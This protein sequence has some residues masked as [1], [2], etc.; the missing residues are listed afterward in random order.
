[1][2]NRMIV[3][4]TVAVAAV[5]IV[6][7]HDLAAV[8][9]LE[10]PEAATSESP[11]GGGTFAYTVSAVPSSSVITVGAC[12]YFTVTVTQNGV[13]VNGATVSVDDPVREVCANA[14]RTNSQGKVTYYVESMCPATK[15]CKVGKY[16]FR[17]YAGGSSGTGLVTVNT[18][19]PSGLDKLR[20]VNSSGNTYKVNVVV[21]GVNRGTTTIS[22]HSTVSLL[23]QSGFNNSTVV[24]T[25][26]NS[27]GTTLWRA[28]QTD[29]GTSNPRSNTF[30]NP[31]Y[32]NYWAN[33]G[34][35]LNGTTV[36]RALH[37]L[38]QVYHDYANKQV[39]V[40]GYSV[41]AS[42]DVGHGVSTDASLGISGPGCSTFLGVSYSCGVSCGISAG[43]QL[44][45]G[46]G[47]GWAIGPV[48][49]GCNAACCVTVAGASC[50][51]VDMSASASATYK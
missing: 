3:L 6:G 5:L 9:G 35:R 42:A 20:V 26:Q 14:G 4:I 27:G 39:S 41:S 17:F 33:T 19:S 32:S 37:G 29:N 31:F 13:P 16:T 23:S 10:Q 15:N 40:G 45:F 49:V 44:C 8:P 38:T 24:A 11:G 18:S 28:T 36:N 1:M 25:V 43:L 50:N 21:N 47:A 7:C 30:Q 22:P 46:G 51:L 34:I 48:D 12:L 2:K